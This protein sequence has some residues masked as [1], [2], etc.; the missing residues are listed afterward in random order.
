MATPLLAIF[1]M[2]LLRL[3]PAGFDDAKLVAA[4]LSVMP[5]KSMVVIELN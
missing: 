5:A 3:L 4:A 1:P 2:K